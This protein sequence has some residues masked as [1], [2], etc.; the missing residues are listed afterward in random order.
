[1]KRPNAQ[2]ELVSLLVTWDGEEARHWSHQLG[3]LTTPALK[4]LLEREA[5]AAARE[6]ENWDGEET[7]QSSLQMAVTQHVLEARP[8][9]LFICIIFKISTSL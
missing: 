6:E 2:E 7:V 5:A 3:G 9:V 4:S 1:L 8:E